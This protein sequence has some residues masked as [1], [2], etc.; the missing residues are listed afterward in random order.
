MPH[1]AGLQTDYKDQGLV[2]LGVTSKDPNNTQDKVEKFVEKRGKKLGYAF[3][4]CD[5]D[6]MD[7]AYMEASGQQGIPCSFVVDKGGKLAFIGHPMQLDDVLPKVLAGTWK[8]EEDVKAMAAAE[9][10]AGDEMKKV[11]AGFESDPVG[12]IDG[13]NAFA[14]KYPSQ[15]KQ[16]MFK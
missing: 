2:V 5:G 8:G 13:L 10:A 7:R 3:A 4:Y 11:M 16:D 14:K 9:K 15:A 1:L 6:A 12:T